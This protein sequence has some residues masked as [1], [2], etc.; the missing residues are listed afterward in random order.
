MA[1]II[2]SATQREEIEKLYRAWCIEG[3]LRES[4]ESDEN[5]VLLHETLKTAEE[6][7]TDAHSYFSP[8]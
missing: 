5:K 7:L 8:L 4:T 6:L 3:Y 2:S 1:K